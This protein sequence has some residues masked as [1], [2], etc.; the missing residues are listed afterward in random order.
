MGADEHRAEMNEETKSD[1]TGEKKYKRRDQMKK[2]ESGA[3]TEEN[4]K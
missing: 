4:V 2:Q 1:S 3:V